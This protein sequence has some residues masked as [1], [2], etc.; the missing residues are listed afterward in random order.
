MSALRGR[1]Q[2]A[3]GLARSLWI[4]RRPGRLSGLKTLYRPLV[5]AGG[6]VFDVGAHLGDRTR[7]FR[8][9]GARVVAVEP[10]PELMRWL[11]RF[12][13]SDPGVELVA[14]ALGRSAGTARLAT[15][16]RHPSLATLASAWRDEVRAGHAGFAQ[17]RWDDEIA[18]PVTTLDALIHRYGRPD[19]IKIDTEGHEP[20]VLAGLSQPVPALSFEFV[21]G[22]LERSLQC[23]Q[24]LERL[25]D[26]EY[27]AVAGEQRR[28][29]WPQWHNAT[30]AMDWL[31][32]GADNLAS[33]DVYARRLLSG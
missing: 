6:L 5:P 18:V 13:G 3:G 12:H 22:T 30:D 24:R 17:V 19:F 28:L 20:E 23:I 11:E 29:R 26:F 10:Q 33:G 27:N 14:G 1:L 2:R 32:A 16:R 4:Y 9:L 7:A 31:N 8:K 21:R 15:S 25:A